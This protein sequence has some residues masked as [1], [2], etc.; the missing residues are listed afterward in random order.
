MTSP[1]RLDAFPDPSPVW[2]VGWAQAW[3]RAGQPASRSL[4]NV[5]RYVGCREM[6]RR[7][8]HAGNLGAHTTLSGDHWPPKELPGAL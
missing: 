3:S 1:V 6:A 2:V 5:N 7:V 4:R 8:R